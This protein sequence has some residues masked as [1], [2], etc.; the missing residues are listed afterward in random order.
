LG[1]CGLGDLHLWQ[2]HGGLLRTLPDMF[3][4]HSEI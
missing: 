2:F 3:I 4:G 1:A